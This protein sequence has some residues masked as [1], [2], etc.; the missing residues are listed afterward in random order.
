MT[1]A[2]SK[3]KVLTMY[4]WTCWVE[5]S[6]TWC[7]SHRRLPKPHG[8][9]RWWNGLGYLQTKY[10]QSLVIATITLKALSSYDLLI[11]L[12]CCKLQNKCTASQEP[13]VHA[14]STSYFG[15]WDG[16]DYGIDL[17]GQK[18]RYY[19]QNNQSQKDYGCGLISRAP[20]SQAQSSEFKHQYCQKKCLSAIW[21]LHME[22]LKYRPSEDQYTV[23]YWFSSLLSRESFCLKVQAE[24]LDLRTSPIRY[25]L[26]WGGCC[27]SLNYILSSVKKRKWHDWAVCKRGLVHLSYYTKIP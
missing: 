15:C 21:L 8:R 12:T 5:N 13:M 6:H 26:T 19:L 11:P 20:A 27:I 25:S 16:E 3:H 9:C 14:C 1:Q 23:L 2:V 7:G 22:I 18:A 4:V 24:G 17:S 10:A